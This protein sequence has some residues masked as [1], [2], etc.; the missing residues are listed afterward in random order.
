MEKVSEA[1]K[2]GPKEGMVI[3]TLAYTPT[4][5]WKHNP[6]VKVQKASI[7]ALHDLFER[8]Y[9]EHLEGYDESHMRDFID[10][11]IRERKRAEKAGDKGTKIELDL[12]SL[13]QNA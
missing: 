2:V 7:A 13:L 1:F 11:Y 10:V 6:F 8:E 4:A 3:L 12:F 5:L 9:K